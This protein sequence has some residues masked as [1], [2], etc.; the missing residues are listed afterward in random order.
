MTFACMQLEAAAVRLTQA[1]LAVAEVVVLAR[2][3]RAIFRL[4]FVR[5]GL[6]TKLNLRRPILAHHVV[7][8][9]FRSFCLILMLLTSPSLAIS[10]DSRSS[11]SRNPRILAEF[12]DERSWHYTSVEAAARV[13]LLDDGGAE[14]RVEMAYASSA[15]KFFSEPRATIVVTDQTGKI[16]SEVSIHDT[17]M[18]M[19][20]GIDSK[21]HGSRRKIESD[22]FSDASHVF[23][24]LKFC[25]WQMGF[26]RT[27][28]ATNGCAKTTVRETTREMSKFA[29]ELATQIGTLSVAIGERFEISGWQGVRLR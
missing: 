2:A 6:T 5:E 9:R 10:G 28:K 8:K 20:S 3:D 18:A 29:D 21:N 15:F 27:I 14:L 26:D 24:R 13:T 23:F 22:A 16:I 4:Q 19:A 17:A 7:T 12:R 11:P 1:Y 25:A